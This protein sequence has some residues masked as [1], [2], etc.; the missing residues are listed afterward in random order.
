MPPRTHSIEDLIGWSGLIEEE[1]K[2]VREYVHRFVEAE[3]MPHIGADFEAGRFRKELVSGLADLGLLGANLHGYGCAGISSVG[4]GLACMELERCDSGLRSFVSVQTSLAMFAIWKF[5]TEAQKQ[6]WLPRMAAGE[7]IGCFGLTEPEHGS[8][9]GGMTTRAVRDGA[10]WRLDGVKTWIT[11]A[12][13]SDVAIVWAKTGPDADSIR[14]FVV[15]RGDAGYTTP[16]IPHKLSMRASSTGSIHLDS[17]YV[18]DDRRFPEIAGLRG[19]LACLNNARFG[20]AFGVLGAARFCLERALAYTGERC[21][22]GV[23]IAAKQLVQSRL[24]DM[25]AEIVK[26][27]LMSLHYGRLKDQGKLSPIH[28]SIMKRNN[29]RI[30]LDAARQNYTLGVDCIFHSDRGSQYTSTDFGDYLRDHRLR[31]SMGRTGVCWDNAMAESFFAS[32]KNEFVYRTVFP[33]RKKAIDSIAH[34]IEIRYNRKRLHSGIGYRT[35]WEAHT[36][37]NTV[38]RAA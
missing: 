36:D 11:S 16:D 1:E 23:P 25:A 15:E 2:A 19:P 10:G 14:G 6:R 38:N 17:V 3:A 37:H 28:V 26:A 12:G 35:P 21:Q 8:D 27:S 5:G 30:A 7:L 18:D 32:L 13:I 22:F 31:G 33:T 9:P 34:W 20:V 29:C 24:A 4:Y